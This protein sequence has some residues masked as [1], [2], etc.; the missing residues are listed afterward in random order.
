M[1]QYPWTRSTGQ[2]GSSG[3]TKAGPDWEPGG[4]RH[5]AASACSCCAA[6]GGCSSVD[7][8]EDRR[9]IGHAAGRLGLLLAL[10]DR[11]STPE[12]SPGVVF[13]VF[14]PP[15]LYYTAYFIAQDDLRAHARPIGSWPSGDCDRAGRRR[16][17]RSSPARGRRPRPA[18]VAPM[19]P[20][21]AGLGVR[22]WNAEELLPRASARA[23]RDRAVSA[24]RLASTRLHHRDRAAGDRT[25]PRPGRSSHPRF[26]SRRPDP[27]PADDGNLKRCRR[28]VARARAGAA[29]PRS[30]PRPRACRPSFRAPPAYRAP[31]PCRPRR[32]A[33]SPTGRTRGRG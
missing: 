5:P 9:A 24:A 11:L 15:L 20:V 14:S 28:P 25:Q 12:L 33:E 2:A 32:S 3:P 27:E 7:V 30:R 19:D 1:T 6:V 22:R 21:E 31:R 4:G 18:M 23:A 29:T 16:G 13:F 8:P 17:A 26:L 10:T